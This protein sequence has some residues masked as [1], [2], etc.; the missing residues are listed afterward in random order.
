MEN[1]I[2]YGL[3]RRLNIFLG[4]VGIEEDETIINNAFR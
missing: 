1:D 3:Y 2:L 4:E